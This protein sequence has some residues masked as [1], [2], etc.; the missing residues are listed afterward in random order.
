MIFKQT[1]P[2]ISVNLRPVSKRVVII[3]LWLCLVGFFSG[4]QLSGLLMG[5]VWK[6][7]SGWW[8]SLVLA[9]GFLCLPAGVGILMGYPLGRTLAVLAFV[10]GY[11]VCAA[12]LAAPLLPADHGITIHG[13]PA[14]FGV[15]A[16]GSLLLLGVLLLLHWT[17]YS[18]PFE[19]HLA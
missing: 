7:P 6:Q 8:P 17:L 5:A 19:D 13:S 12:L 18:P 14:G 11:F 15:H 2:S 10:V 9:A 16:A 1:G 3:C 4:W